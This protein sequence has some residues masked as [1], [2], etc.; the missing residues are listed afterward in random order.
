MPQALSFLPFEIDHIIAR[1]HRGKTTSGN[2]ALACAYDNGFKG[3][4]IAGLDPR[5]NRL[6]RLFHPRHHLWRRHFQWDGPVLVGRT[7]IG[8][9]TVEVLGM[10]HPFRIEQRRVLIAANLFPPASL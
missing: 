7:P 4:N 5:T 2:L 9:T 1:Q 6:V 3:P 8:R 10:N